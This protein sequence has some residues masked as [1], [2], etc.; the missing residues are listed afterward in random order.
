MKVVNCL[1]W[2]WQ[3]RLYIGTV[4]LKVIFTKCLHRHER[5][6]ELYVCFPGVLTYPFLVKQSS[7]LPSK[8]IQRQDSGAS[9]GAVCLPVTSPHSVCT[10]RAQFQRYL[11]HNGWHL[12]PGV[13]LPCVT[14]LLFSSYK[15]CRRKWQPTPVFLPRESHGQ[16]SLVGCCP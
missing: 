4:I 15:I 3:A 5:W 2:F 14:N 12:G 7:H 9:A 8:G 13:R 10:Q 1:L 11:W 16:R 6:N